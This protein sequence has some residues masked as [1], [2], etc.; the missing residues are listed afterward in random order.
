[1]CAADAE[2]PRIAANRDARSTVT[3]ARVVSVS[4]RFL[5]WMNPP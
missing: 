1:L 4:A 3:T 5:T 2:L